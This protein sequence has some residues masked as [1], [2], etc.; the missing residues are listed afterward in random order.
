M[1]G[2]GRL[3]EL[4]DRHGIEHV[5]GT[6]HEGD[7]D[8]ATSWRFDELIFTAVLDDDGTLDIWASGCTPEQA[9]E[10]ALAARRSALAATPSLTL[11]YDG[12]GDATFT[13]SCGWSETLSNVP[14]PKFCRECGVE[15]GWPGTADG[16]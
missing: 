1:N 4:L 2:I 15:L 7:E 11:E 10:T 16:S 13:C 6:F 9:M 3:K 5:D 14:L 8:R 12:N